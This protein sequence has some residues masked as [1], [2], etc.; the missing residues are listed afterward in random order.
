MEKFVCIQKNEYQ[1]AY[2]EIKAG[3]K[4]SHWIWYIFPQIAGLGYSIMSRNYEIRSLD[5]AREYLK[6][7][8]LRN[9]L[10]HILEALL[11]HESKNICDIFDPLDAQKLLSCMT[12][13][14]EASKNSKYEDIFNRVI[15]VFYNGKVDMR[16]IEILNRMN[17]SKNPY[18]N[19]NFNINSLPGEKNKNVSGYNYNYNIQKNIGTNEQ[20]KKNDAEL[21]KNNIVESGNNNKHML[22]SSTNYSNAED[23]KNVSNLYQSNNYQNQFFSTKNN[24][25]NYKGAVTN[26][27]YANGNSKININNSTSLNKNTNE[28]NDSY[29]I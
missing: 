28:S 24:S 14:K 25:D 5:E 18:P 19:N 17:Y 10:I 9:N 22:S 7:D 26:Y 11:E 27:Y 12:L 20:L 29:L 21:K 16:T 3:K 1:K 23:F 8:Y 2:K 4:I 6:N 15:K 13:F